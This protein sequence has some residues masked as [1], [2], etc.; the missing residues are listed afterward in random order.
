ME[1]RVWKGR[2]YLRLRSRKPSSEEVTEAETQKIGRDQ[3]CE[4]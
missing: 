2:T 4:T 3:P 1:V